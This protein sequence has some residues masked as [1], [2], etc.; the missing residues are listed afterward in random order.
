VTAGV[1]WWDDIPVEWP[2]L[3]AYWLDDVRRWQSMEADYGVHWRRGA[4]RWPSWRVSYGQD[5][6]ELFA[7]RTVPPGRGRYPSNG[8]LLLA[9]VPPDPVPCQRCGEPAAAHY[10][11]IR[12][13][14]PHPASPPG[15]PFRGTGSWH[16]TLD[17]LLDGWAD[18]AVTGLDLAW[19]GRRLRACGVTTVVDHA[20]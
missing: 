11:A 15:H 1:T 17:R 20:W 9:A 2:S 5:T 12:P 8:V 6:G 3:E 14:N 13:D 4:S 7:V 16:A 19:C 18:A 10:P